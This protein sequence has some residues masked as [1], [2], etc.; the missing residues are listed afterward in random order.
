MAVLIRWGCQHPQ[1]SRSPPALA[2]RFFASNWTQTCTPPETR[3]SIGVTLN[4]T[5]LTL[6][7]SYV[8]RLLL[9]FP[10]PPSG[11]STT[12]LQRAAAE[13]SKL[14]GTAASLTYGAFTISGVNTGFNPITAAVYG[15]V[16]TATSASF[17]IPTAGSFAVVAEAARV[18]AAN[19]LWTLSC[20]PAGPTVSQ[21]WNIYGGQAEAG[22]GYI[23]NISAHSAFVIGATNPNAN[24]TV[25]NL[26][27]D[28]IFAPAPLPSFTWAGSG[29]GGGN[30]TWDFST[31][32][33]WLN[34]NVGA[35]QVYANTLPVIFTDAG[36][37]TTINLTS[38]ATISPVSVLFQSNTA[39]YT[40]T[41]SGGGTGISG[42]AAVTL[43]GTGTVTF[44]LS[45]SYSGGTA[46]QSGT[47][48]AGN[49]GPAH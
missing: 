48:I 12:R 33:D 38:T 47:L 45:N 1:R 6:G 20:S 15:Y 44:N 37:N 26:Q 8:P 9:T 32:N 43:V 34:P 28:E 46:L 25:R 42:S 22:G 17:N 24:N 39:S 10:S 7:A 4:G 18:T 5:P 41:Q 11:T 36:L 13:A 29:G 2:A 19:S 35:V 49:A 27:V 31:T 3:P 30:A 40:F 23:S 21:Q 14:P 16:N